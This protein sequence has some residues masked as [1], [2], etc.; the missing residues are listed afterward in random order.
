M[1]LLAALLESAPQRLDDNLGVPLVSSLV[2]FCLLE[3]SGCWGRLQ[4]PAFIHDLMVG[5]ALNV[6]LVVGA[7]VLATLDAKGAIVACLLGTVVFAFLSWA[8]YAVLLTFF[9]L[10]SFST[11]IGYRPKKEIRVAEG[12][13]GRRRAAN[14]LANGSVAAACALLAG[15]TVHGQLFIAA[16][17]C[18]L[19]AATADTVESEIGQVWGRPTILI[20]NW[21]PVSPGVDGGISALGTTAGLM[22]S[23]ITVGVGSMAGLYSPTVVLPLSLLALAATMAE[24]VAGATLERSGLLNN[25][26]VNFL[27]TLLAAMLGAGLATIMG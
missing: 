3:T 16:F 1:A 20:T 22:A 23:L 25:D 26:G 7:Y 13:G 4:E 19:G 5:S 15:T 12:R 9:I 18:S 14:A 8:G 2:L 21:R 27:N 24:S 10:G 11:R 17:A 6:A